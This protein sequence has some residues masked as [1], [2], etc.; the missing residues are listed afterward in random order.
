MLG[1]PVIATYL[2]LEGVLSGQLTMQAALLYSGLTALCLIL[3]ALTNVSSHRILWQVQTR[4]VAALQHRLGRHLRRIPLGTLQSRD[5]GVFETLITQHAAELNFVTPPAQAIR[6][7]VAPLISL[8]MLTWIDWRLA[9]MTFAT[10]PAFAL[11]V[12]WSE[13]IV[14]AVASQLVVSQEQLS[15]RI[16]D[17]VQG[18]PT[19]RSLGLGGQGFASLSQALEHHRR[20]S[21]ETVTRVTPPV[22]I[23]WSVLDLGFC[24]LLAGGGLLTASGDLAPQTYLLFLVIGLVLYGPI[25]DAFDLAAYRRLL[26]RTMQRVR[27]ALDL[28]VLPESPHPAR[29]RSLDIRFEKVS[30]NYDGIPAL[31]GIDLHFRAGLMHAITGPSGSGKSTVLALLS[32]FWDPDEGQITVGGVDL[33]EVSSDMRAR[34]FAAVF[35]ETYLFD[36]SVAANIRLGK[37]DATLAEVQAAARAAQC[38]DF[39]SALEYGYD[40]R[41]GEAGARLSGGE[42][43]R[44]AIARAILKDA[45]I[46]LLDEAT[47]SIDPDNEH[48]IRTALAALCA[49]KTVILIAHR[50]NTIANVDQVVTIIAGKVAEQR[51]VAEATASGEGRALSSR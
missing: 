31:R 15:S 28:P 37:P 3:Q 21:H 33:R 42:R 35:Q 20:V 7:L 47:A 46:L 8:I 50:P 38:H 6:I 40:T 51:S 5:T 17:Y 25:A 11:A 29:P 2:T 1:A 34:L 24:V 12:V 32:R 48:D 39:I 13:R 4:A 14:R 19:L 18:M 30:F 49:G 22:A 23:G 44:I 43:Q 45:P 26:E 27:A 41:V 9:L 16:L 36:D 10:L